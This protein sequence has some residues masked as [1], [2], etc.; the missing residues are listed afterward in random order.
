MNHAIITPIQSTE[1]DNLNLSL[2]TVASL[3][4]EVH[5]SGTNFKEDD[6]TK[7]KR[8]ISEFFKIGDLVRDIVDSRVSAMVF[9]VIT[10]C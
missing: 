8:L 9:C 4:N 3:E 6:K 1:N 2:V 10:A 7:V 5:R